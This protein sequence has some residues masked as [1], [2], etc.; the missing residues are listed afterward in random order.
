VAVIAVEPG[1]SFTPYP[2]ISAGLEQVSVTYNSTHPV[3]IVA[4]GTHCD[5]PH[6]LILTAEEP[7]A[8]V[9]AVAAVV[10]ATAAVVGALPA[11]TIMPA[12][13]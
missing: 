9:G 8:V 13:G 6:N 7:L 4:L 1:A 3:L 10:G 11:P 2:P 5:P 12:P